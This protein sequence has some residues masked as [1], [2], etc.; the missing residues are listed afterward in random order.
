MGLVLSFHY[1]FN[2]EDFKDFLQISEEKKKV[3]VTSSLLVPAPLN[4]AT[5]IAPAAR[6]K[7]QKHNRWIYRAFVFFTYWHAFLNTAV[8]VN[9]LFYIL[10]GIFGD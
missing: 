2:S 5:A 3:Q 9:Y 7:P 8:T 1:I 4:L 10:A 6:K